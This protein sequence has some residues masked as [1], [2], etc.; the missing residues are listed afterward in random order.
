MLYGQLFLF[1]FVTCHLQHVCCAPKI[2]AHLLKC[3]LQWEISAG[4]TAPANWKCSEIPQVQSGVRAGGW[5]S[6]SFSG[7]SYDSYLETGEKNQSWNDELWIL[8]TFW[9]PTQTDALQ[10]SPW[11]ADHREDKNQLQLLRAVWAPG[12]HCF[13]RS[14]QFLMSG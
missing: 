10:S 5:Q 3:S 4:R 6:G 13:M 7:G 1:Y 12:S 14:L 9:V 11:S 8:S 2:F